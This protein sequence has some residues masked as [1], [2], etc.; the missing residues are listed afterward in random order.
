MKHLVGKRITKKVPFMGDEVEIIKLS[1]GQVLEVQKLLNKSSKSK[2]EESQVELIRDV[3]KLAVIGANELS[4]EDFK[5]FP[6][7]ELNEL[8]EAIIS[9][10][11]LGGDTA[12]E[13]N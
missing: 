1:V 5:Q 8:S 7:A 3:V 13:G 10:S 9:Y 11:G 2:S 12:E 6:L 4:N